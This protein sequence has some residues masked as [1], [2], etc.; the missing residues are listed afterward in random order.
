MSISRFKNE[1]YQQV[2]VKIKKVTQRRKDIKSA[3]KKRRKYT[4]S[5]SSFFLSLTKIK[6]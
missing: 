4:H 1:T 6:I 2:V 5:E 3:E